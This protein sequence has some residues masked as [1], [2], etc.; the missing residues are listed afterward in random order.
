MEEYIHTSKIYG[1][2]FHVIFSLATGDLQLDY[3]N[4]SCP[5]AEE[6]I[7][8][9]VTN[10]YHKHGNTAVSWIRNLFHDCIV[11]VKKKLSKYYFNIH[12]MLVF[13]FVLGNARVSRVSLR[14]S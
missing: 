13:F 10:L 6:I 9:Q 2:N 3:Y 4:D 14:A 8:E 1:T 11:K 7:K 12:N 5:R